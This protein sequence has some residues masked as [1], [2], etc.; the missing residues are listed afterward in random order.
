MN[1]FARYGVYAVLSVL[2]SVLIIVGQRVMMVP[3]VYSFIAK[4]GERVGMVLPS[5]YIAQARLVSDRPGFWVTLDPL[6]RPRAV[7]EGITRV[8]PEL[9][10][11]SSSSMVEAMDW[12]VPVVIVV[13]YLAVLFL[14]ST[15]SLWKHS[16][17]AYC[18]IR[19]WAFVGILSIGSGVCVVFATLFWGARVFWTG[20]N[21]A[22]AARSMVQVP[23]GAA[24]R[25]QNDALLAMGTSG[26]VMLL[27]AM[28]LT[29]LPILVW[30]DMKLFRQIGSGDHREAIYKHMLLARLDGFFS[31]RMVR[32]AC[33]ACYGAVMVFLWT[34]P[35]ST[36]ML[37]TLWMT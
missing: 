5:G 28:V 31:E 11:A 16:R 10:S 36:T 32:L 3:E 12:R 23:G 25:V 24:I 18:T 14:V 30:V 6:T 20:A 2:M 1:R 35:W 26:F 8:H 7:P 13:L 37:N 22:F 19:P 17:D 21:Q 4:M 33:A 34:W 29:A 9:I 27:L 15:I